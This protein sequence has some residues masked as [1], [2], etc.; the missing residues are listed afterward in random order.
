MKRFTESKTEKYYDAEDKIYLSFWDSKGTCHF[1]LF[2]D[3]EN[4]I[5]ASENLTNFMIKSASINT[6]SIVL[7]VGCGDGE[8]DVQI[9]KKTGCKIV[10][11]DLSGVRIAHAKQKVKEQKLEPLVKFFKSSATNLEFKDNHFTH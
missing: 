6:S 11:L 1:G 4:H 3:D 2:N 9:V 7:D 5:L 8:V 10:G